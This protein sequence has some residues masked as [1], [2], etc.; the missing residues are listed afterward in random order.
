[1]NNLIKLDFKRA[2][3]SKNFYIAL[4]ITIL[5][6]FIALYPLLEWKQEYD[7]VNAWFRCIGA[8]TAYITL[9]FP[10]IVAI[11]YSSIVATERKNFFLRYSFIRTNKK[12]Y[13]LSKAIV[14]SICGGL[15]LFIPSIILLIICTKIFGN[16]L[17]FIDELS[18][19]NEPFSFIL[20]NN[21]VLYMFSYS[22]W[23]FF[24]GMIWSTV[25]FAISLITNN[26]LI[27]T[28]APFLYSIISSFILSIFRLEAF[29]AS[30]SFSPYLMSNSTIIT[31]LAQPIFLTIFIFCITVYYKKAT[32]ESYD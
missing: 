29:T 14:N 11:P 6:M 23:M 8:G 32:E 1:M 18:S 28:S 4:T 15:V 24:Q 5:L 7:Y 3:K 16:P 17:N 2:L 22:L 12:N 20:K 31:I 19:Y 27:I 13:L 10:L 25:C 21:P 30:A 26:I 9:L